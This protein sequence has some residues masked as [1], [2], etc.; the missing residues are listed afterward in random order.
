MHTSLRLTSLGLP[1]PATTST[2]SHRRSLSASAITVTGMSPYYKAHATISFMEIAATLAN[3]QAEFVSHSL[4]NTANKFQIHLFDLT[5]LTRNVKSTMSLVAA[6]VLLVQVLCSAISLGKRVTPGNASI[7]ARPWLSSSYPAAPHSFT[8]ASAPN[9]DW[10]G[11]G[12]RV[13]P[14]TH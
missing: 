5:V 10:G 3:E 14:V 4:L 2:L 12:G 11:G 7:A 6:P 1:G 13:T 9:F 8:G